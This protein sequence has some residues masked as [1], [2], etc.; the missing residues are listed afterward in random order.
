MAEFAAAALASFA[1]VGAAAG[2]SA[3]LGAGSAAVSGGGFLAGLTSF[4]GIAASVL[5]GAATIGSVL[6]TQQGAE[7][8]AQS[9][10]LQA[11]DAEMNVKVEQNQGIE[12]RNSLKAA[13][14][15]AIGD[16]SVATAASGVDL[17]FGTPVQAR[18]EAVTAEQN[19][20]ASDVRTEEF[21]KSRLLERAA[22]YRLMA[23]QE[24]SG[25]L[26]K[27][28]GIGAS[29]FANLLRRGVAL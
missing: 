6:A 2:G 15:Q 10:E 12:R 23:S 26:A 17:S 28:A 5:S 18:Q 27:A 9:L 16:R 29:G 1:E 11:L 20:L 14:V 4:G 8:K 24:R 13:L 3:A 21:R 25:G 19:A 22:S 7:Q